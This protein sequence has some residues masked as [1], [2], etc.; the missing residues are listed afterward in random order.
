M[1]DI[2]TLVEKAAERLDKDTTDQLN[3]RLQKGIFDLS[4]MAAQLRQV[5]KI[6]GMSGIMSMLPGA[7]ALKGKMSSM[8][9]D[10]KLVKKQLA[11]IGSMTPRERKYPKLLN[12]SRKRRVANGSGTTVQDINVLLKQFEG[13]GKMMKQMNKLGRKGMLRQG[14]SNLLKP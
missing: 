10:D 14:L 13:M 1:G 3:R 7:E 2:V 6:G 5:Q 8:G 12:S 9:M 11:I 4:D